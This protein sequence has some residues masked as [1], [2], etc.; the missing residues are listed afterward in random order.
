MESSSTCRA[1]RTHVL[2]LRTVGD[3]ISYTVAK[4]VVCFCQLIAPKLAQR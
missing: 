3:L 4:I 1:I 2:Y